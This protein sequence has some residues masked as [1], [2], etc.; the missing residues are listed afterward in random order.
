MKYILSEDPTFTEKNNYSSIVIDIFQHS[1][2]AQ[3]HTYWVIDM[4]EEAGGSTTQGCESLVAE[5]CTEPLNEFIPFGLED[6]FLL[7]TAAESVDTFVFMFVDSFASII[8]VSTCK[9]EQWNCWYGSRGNGVLPSLSDESIANLHIALV[10]GDL[11]CP[12]NISSLLRVDFV[13]VTSAWH[14]RRLIIW[15]PPIRSKPDTDKNR[16]RHTTLNNTV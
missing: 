15:L 3:R 12:E 1:R 2:F 13:P 10:H 7:A 9:F 8:W 11:S 6:T 16:H 5:A 14:D 4:S